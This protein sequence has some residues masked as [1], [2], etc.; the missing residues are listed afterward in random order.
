MKKIF[1]QLCFMIRCKWLG[2][3]AGVFRK[4]YYRMQGMRIGRN[5]KLP[6]IF[7]TWPHQVYLG[8]E[9]KLERNIS[10][11]YDGIWKPGS[12]IVIQDQVFVGKDCEFNI[13]QGI[14]IGKFSNVASGCK[15]IDH[16]HG[17]EL[18]SRIGPQPSI[19]A[20]IELGEDVW[21]GC[22]VIVLKGVHIGNGA[23]VAAGAVVTKSIPPNEIW[24]GVP[25]R[26]IS[27]RT[28][29]GKQED[30]IAHFGS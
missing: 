9:C 2:N 20:A 13:S 22:N 21:L 8:N 24:A 12:A 19:A 6:R 26:R 29:Y 16:D 7:V 15:F 10:F 14:R 17:I 5:T 4:N 23:V 11:K 25:A 30:H 28:S 27:E 18:G 3:P 1:Q